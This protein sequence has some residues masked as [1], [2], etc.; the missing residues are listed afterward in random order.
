MINFNTWIDALLS[1]KGID[2]DDTIEV[3]G[4]SGWNLMPISAVID[5]IKA[6]SKSERDQIKTMLVRIDFHNGD[7]KHYI[8]H[9]AQAIAI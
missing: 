5:A 2:P 4:A 7:V 9:L 6:T 3:D 8:Q 1:E